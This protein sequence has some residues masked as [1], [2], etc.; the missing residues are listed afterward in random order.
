[1]SVIVG[2]LVMGWVTC[3]IASFFFNKYEDRDLSALMGVLWPLAIIAVVGS[4]TIEVCSGLVSLIPGRV[5]RCIYIALSLVFT[6]W[7][8]GRM[9]REWREGK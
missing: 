9:Y 5:A 6:P 8:I 3:A 1:L 2:Y 7:N 4:V